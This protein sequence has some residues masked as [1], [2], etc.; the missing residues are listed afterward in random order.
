MR[1]SNRSLASGNDKLASFN[2]SS[3]SDFFDSDSA[4]Y[5]FKCYA[6]NFYPSILNLFS[7]F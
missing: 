5:S 2:Y 3:K 7:A 4:I 6:F 1:F